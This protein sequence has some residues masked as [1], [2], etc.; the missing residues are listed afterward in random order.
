MEENNPLAKVILFQIDKTSKVA[1]QYSQKEFDR[2]GLGITVD[3]WVLLKIIEESA[4]LSQKEL[5][6]HSL[7]DPA[8]ITRTLDLL[9]KKQ[10][11]QREN[12]TGNRRQYNIILTT[13][14][15]TFVDANIALVNEHR[16]KSTA[17]LSEK[18]LELLQRMLLKIQQN[19]QE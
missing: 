1:K 16:R 15:K 17:G 8:S 7:R 18:E 10:L 5:A 12:I 19:M 3:Q 9:E 2:L 11:I 13:T 4:P 6:K 14:G